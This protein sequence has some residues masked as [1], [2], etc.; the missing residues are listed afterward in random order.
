MN[1]DRCGGCLHWRP[2]V[3]PL[4]IGQRKGECRESPPQIALAVSPSGAMV[5][6]IAYPVTDDQFAACSRFEPNETN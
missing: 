2:M 4:E 5:N 1:G 3:S 6:V